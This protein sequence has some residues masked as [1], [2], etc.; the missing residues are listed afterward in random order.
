M[1]LLLGFIGGILLLVSIITLLFSP[2]VGILFL[3]I[4]I[5]FFIFSKNIV[6]WLSSEDLK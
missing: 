1:K 3:L 6:Q 5:L 2:I 4:W